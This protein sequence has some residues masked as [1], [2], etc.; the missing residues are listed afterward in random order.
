MRRDP[1]REC[2]A[3]LAVMMLVIAAPL[4]FCSSSDAATY[5]QSTDDGL[6]ITYQI[7]DGGVKTVGHSGTYKGD[8]V[9]LVIPATVTI[10]GKDYSVIAIGESSFNDWTITS[11]SIPGTVKVIGANAFN[12]C[13]NVTEIRFNGT[14]DEKNIGDNAFALGSENHPA[15]CTVHGFTPTRNVWDVEDNPYDDIF[16]KYTTVHYRD[17]TPDNKDSII[18]IAL[19]SIGVFLLLYMGRCVKVKKI[20]RKKIRKKR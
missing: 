19:I 17:L 13:Y 20:K 6:E 15:E 1:K 2:L 12:G 16:G 11:I 10:E 5:E 4:M 9:G 14:I 18:H 3:I 8:K 7:I